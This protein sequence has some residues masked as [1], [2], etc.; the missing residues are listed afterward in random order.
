MKH[1][2]QRS[3]HNNMNLAEAGINIEEF[4]EPAECEQA[5]AGLLTFVNNLIEKAAGTFDSLQR[6][7]IYLEAMKVSNRAYDL[8]A[9]AKELEEKRRIAKG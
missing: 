4:K 9:R 6:H 8:L 3:F 1:D 2:V 5:A 7:E